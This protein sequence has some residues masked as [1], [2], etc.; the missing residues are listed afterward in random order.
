MEWWSRFSE[1]FILE[2]LIA[3]SVS[4][5]GNQTL[6]QQMWHDF[7]WICVADGEWG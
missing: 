7:Y 5:G 6:Q 1:L 2:W 4:G 3:L